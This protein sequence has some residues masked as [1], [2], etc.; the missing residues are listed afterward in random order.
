[1]RQAYLNALANPGKVTTP[2]AVMQPGARP[3][4]APQPSVL[5]AFLAAHPSGGTQ[6]PGGYGN[7]GF[8]STLQNLQAQK[9]TGS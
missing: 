3:T 9:G 2:G 8:F 1:M 5:N 7:Q 6:I 4:G